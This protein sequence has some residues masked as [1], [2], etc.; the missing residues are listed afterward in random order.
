MLIQQCAVSSESRRKEENK[1]YKQTKNTKFYFIDK[2][3]ESCINLLSFFFFNLCCGAL[4][5]AAT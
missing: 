2:I 3:N 4:G 5:T 1:E